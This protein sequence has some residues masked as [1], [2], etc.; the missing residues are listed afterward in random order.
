MSP[1]CGL[2]F[3]T[4]A[5]SACRTKSEGHR[6]LVRP[7]HDLARVKVRGRGQE[8][9]ALVDPDL[10]PS[11]RPGSAR[12]AQRLPRCYGLWHLGCLGKSRRSKWRLASLTI[13][14][15]V[16]ISCAVAVVGRRS[17]DR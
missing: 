9:P 7:T 14:N 3:H 4:A 12:P 5:I 17:E 1:A 16:V 2:R 8:Q 13:A 10:E 15:K 6:W 11:P